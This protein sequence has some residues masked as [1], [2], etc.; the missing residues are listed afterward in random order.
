MSQWFGENNLGDLSKTGDKKLTLSPSFLKINGKAV[1]SSELNLDLETNGVGGLDTGNL[2]ANTF[3]NVFI[4]YHENNYNL[5][6]SKNSEISYS[7]YYK[8]ASFYTDAE[9]NVSNKIVLDYLKDSY[10]DSYSEINDITDY[11]ISEFQCANFKQ[12]FLSNYS[13]TDIAFGNNVFL[14]VGN[15]NRFAYSRDGYNFE[16]GVVNS[17]FNSVFFKNK[18]FILLGNGFIFY[19]I[20]GNLLVKTMDIADVASRDWANTVFYSNFY[21]CLAKNGDILKIDD[22][23]LFLNGSYDLYSSGISDLDQKELAVGK[24]IFVSVGNQT[25]KTSDLNNFE[26]IESPEKYYSIT[27]GRNKFVAINS[28]KIYYSENGSSWNLAHTASPNQTFLKVRYTGGIFT[29]VGDNCFLISYD[30]INWESKD[31][32]NNSYYNSVIFGKNCF[33]AV[34]NTLSQYIISLSR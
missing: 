24:G 14:I 26:I 29:I 11:R 22:R 7:F 32:F 15:G 5:I 27:F 30:G 18:F 10:L 2:E 31:V 4:V 13:W 8:I 25:V 1:Y 34:S 21:Y 33:T 6:S 17:N 12:F 19:S 23:S 20:D 16:I 3:Y 9:S 28:E